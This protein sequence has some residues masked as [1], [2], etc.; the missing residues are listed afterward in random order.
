MVIFHS[1][2]SLPEGNQKAV[3]N[4]MTRN[5]PS[6]WYC[7]FQALCRVY[8]MEFAMV[9]H[10][11]N[12]ENLPEESLGWIS[13]FP[14]PWHASGAEAHTKPAIWEC[15]EGKVGSSVFE[16]WRLTVFGEERLHHGCWRYEWNVSTEPFSSM[17]FPM[18]FRWNL[19]FVGICSI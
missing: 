15:I 18:I 14:S 9:Y 16:V 2:V 11:T 13:P 8:G 10:M 5:Y 17:D 3:I 1:Y 19:Q 6:A 4:W 12:E 7:N